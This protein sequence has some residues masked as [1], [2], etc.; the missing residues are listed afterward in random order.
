MKSESDLTLIIRKHLEE[1]GYTTYGE[2]QLKAGNIRCDL[3]AVKDKVSIAI[4][5]KLTFSF[6]VLNQAYNWLNHANYVYVLVP[7]V[8]RGKSRKFAIQC[9]KSLGIGVIEVTK[10][11]KLNIVEGDFNSKPKLPK[12]Y[13]EQKDTVASNSKNEYITEFKLTVNKINDYMVDKNKCKLTDVIKN[14]NHHYKTDKSAVSA[15]K[16][17]IDIQVI[18]NYY[19]TKEGRSLFLNKYEF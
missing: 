2:V 11:G 4:E 12:L 13:D 6:K 19:I 16:K 10:A 15:I 7:A 3:F 14:I 8:R 1:E 5:A 17:M 18:E 9:A